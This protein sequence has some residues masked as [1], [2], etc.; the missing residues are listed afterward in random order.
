[1]LDSIGLWFDRK[2]SGDRQHIFNSIKEH[3]QSATK[4]PLLLFPEGTCVNNEYCVMFK[5]GAFEIGATVYPIAIKYNRLFADTFYN[6]RKQSFS[7]HLL[8]VLTSWAVVAEVWFL[9]PQ[10][11]QPGESVIDFTNRVKKLIA[12]K[13]GLKNVSWDGYLKYFQPNKKFVEERQKLFASS[14]LARYSQAN[15]VE[16]EESFLE[17]EASDPRNELRNTTGSLNWVP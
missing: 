16:L 13:A 10:T 1:L 8:T 14:L 15:L 5:K 3:A 17:E 12:K 6:S 7:R 9:E 4:N 11:Q 2:D